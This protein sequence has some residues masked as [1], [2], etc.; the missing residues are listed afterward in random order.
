[1]DVPM[2]RM[3]YEQTMARG[4]EQYRDVLDALMA[5]GLPAEFTQTGGMCAGIEVPLGGGHYL[6]LTELEDTL[7]WARIEHQG[8]SVGLYEPEERRTADGALRWLDDPDGSPEK[9]VELTRRA[10]RGESGD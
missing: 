5:A 9:A 4:A 7:S 2:E 6:L 1:M 3:T 8:W 10:L